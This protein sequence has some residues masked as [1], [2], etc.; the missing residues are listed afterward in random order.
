[1]KRV[2]MYNIVL[3]Y[4]TIKLCDKIPRKNAVL[5]VLLHQQHIQG[6]VAL[7]LY[8]RLKITVN[9]KCPAAF[10]L[11]MIT[12]K[13]NIFNSIYA[14]KEQFQNASFFD[15]RALNVIGT[16]LKLRLTVYIG[17]SAPQHVG[18]I[19]SQQKSCIII[20]KIIK[21]L[22]LKRIRSNAKRVTHG[23]K[24]RELNINGSW[25]I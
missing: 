1:M 20:Q 13:T 3:L 2:E 14:R 16:I 4:W 25:F 5:N 7:R 9:K 19:T 23:I 15:Q 22:S 11:I 18:K 10:M 6:D 24:T 8:D 12:R 21:T 17:T